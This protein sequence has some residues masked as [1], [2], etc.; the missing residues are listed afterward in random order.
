[1]AAWHE[2]PARPPLPHLAAALALCIYLGTML[3]LVSLVLWKAR[4]MIAG[5]L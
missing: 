1:M 2:P 4:H 3:G 5:V